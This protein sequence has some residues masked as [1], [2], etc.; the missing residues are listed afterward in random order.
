MKFEVNISCIDNDKSRLWIEDKLHHFI[1]DGFND[2]YTDGE[3]INEPIINI[4]YKC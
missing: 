2:M 3:I 1:L 4:S